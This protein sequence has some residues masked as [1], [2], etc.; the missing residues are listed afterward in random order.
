MS[1]VFEFSTKSYYSI[2][3]RSKDLLLDLSI[4]KLSV[5]DSIITYLEICVCQMSFVTALC[6]HIIGEKLVWCEYQALSLQEKYFLFFS[7]Q[8]WFHIR[9]FCC[10]VSEC[11]LEAKIK[12]LSYV[13]WHFK[14]TMSFLEDIVFYICGQ[15]MNFFTRPRRSQKEKLCIWHSKKWMFISG[16]KYK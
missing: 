12:I 6:N 4:S 15:E 10:A 11:N 14:M 3:T 8:M 9:N 16:E 7:F 2:R 13:K 5:V 1:T